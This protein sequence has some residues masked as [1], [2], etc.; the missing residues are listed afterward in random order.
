MEHNNY[1]YI[2]TTINDWIKFSDMKASFVLASN[3]I[4]MGLFGTI[5]KDLILPRFGFADWIHISFSITIFLYIVSVLMSA[6][7]AIWVIYPK[8]SVNEAKSHIY[9]AHIA[10]TQ[11][12]TYISELSQLTNEDFNKEI[13]DQIFAVSKVCW[14]KYKKT[15]Y[16]I[17][18]L[19][20]SIF[21]GI[22]IIL[23][24]LFFDP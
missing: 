20:G 18:G 11:A 19:F 1:T 5:L 4:M 8:L 14:S 3:G 21:F 10:K 13:A 7:S 12:P 2:Y 17:R 23:L 9:F 24:C 16:S 6:I 15:N 22:I